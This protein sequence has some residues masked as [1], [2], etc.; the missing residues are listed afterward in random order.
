MNM[1]WW[2]WFFL[3]VIIVYHPIMSVVERVRRRP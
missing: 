1:A 2:Q 3:V